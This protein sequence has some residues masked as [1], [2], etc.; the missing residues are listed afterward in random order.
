M[1]WS[2]VATGL[3]YIIHTNAQAI[4]AS[5]RGF[6]T[7]YYDIEHTDSCDTS[8]ADQ[9]AGYVN[10]SMA[11][12]TLEQI[13]SNYLVAMN[14]TQLVQDPAKYCG[15]RV[16]VSVNGRQSNLPLF[17]GDSCKRC[18]SG[19]ASNVVWDP[20][21]APGLDFSFT[22][23]NELSKNACKDGHVLLSWKIVNKTVY[24]FR[25]DVQGTATRN[26]QT[27]ATTAVSPLHTA[28]RST[29]IEKPLASACPTGEWRCKGNTLEQ[30]V[31]ESWTAR[32]TCGIGM[33]CQRAEENVYCGTTSGLYI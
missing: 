25:N 27:P 32:A 22:V 7:Y 14:Y 23:L 17:I 1:V 15:K 16:V 9:N 11:P 10:C 29:W 6:G 30:C 24:N 19:S 33:T 13:N 21:G 31:T 18:S 4:I 12:L 8:F 26:P 5:G 2:I 28:A 20:N 3:L